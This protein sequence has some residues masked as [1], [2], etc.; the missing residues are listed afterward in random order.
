VES[1]FFGVGSLVW[2]PELKKA[3]QQKDWFLA[4]DWIGLIEE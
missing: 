2:V 4:A 3:E 1:Q